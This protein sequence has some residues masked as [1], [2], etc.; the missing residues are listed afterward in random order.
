MA[1]VHSHPGRGTEHSD[2]D[3]EFAFMP[4]EGMFSI[5]V[6][7]YGDGGITAAGGAGIHQFQ[8]SVWKRVTNPDNALMLVPSIA[9]P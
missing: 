6:A 2:G 1:Q 8:S 7:S 9:F 4:R 3:D 5:V